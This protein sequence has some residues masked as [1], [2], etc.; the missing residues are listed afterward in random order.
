MSPGLFAL[1]EF[2]DLN[3]IDT[4]WKDAHAECVTDDEQ[5]NAYTIMCQ[6]YVGDGKRLPKQPCRPRNEMGTHF[7]WFCVGLPRPDES[8][9]QQLKRDAMAV[10]GWLHYDIVRTGLNGRESPA[11]FEDAVKVWLANNAHALA[12]ADKKLRIWLNNNP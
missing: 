4:G 1:M 9:P 10:I 5:R 11:P 8:K 7:S 3:Y 2:F 12:S 6:L